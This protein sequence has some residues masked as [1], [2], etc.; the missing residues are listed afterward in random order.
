MI[1]RGN[2]LLVKE[3]LAYQR[4]VMQ[5]DAKSIKRYWSYLKHLLIWADDVRFS[6]VT[7]IRPTFAMYIKSRSVDSGSALP[8]AAPTLKKILQIA[9][10]FFIW[11]KST[12]PSRF[13]DIPPAWVDALRLPHSSPDTAP[14]VFVTL[15]EVLKLI[16]VGCATSDLA[17]W[18]DQAAPPCYFS[19]APAPPRLAHSPWSASIF[20]TAP[21]SK[22]PR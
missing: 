21:S 20:P 3:F 2:Y 18:R 5:L 13:R 15:P 10:R 12:Y 17:R 11:V 14:H 22:Y 8:L 16:Q 6:Q 7:E 19:L 9:K 1:E 4:E